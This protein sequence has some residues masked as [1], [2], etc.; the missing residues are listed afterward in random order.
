[1]KKMYMKP[2]VKISMNASLEGVFACRGDYGCG[3]R[4]SGGYKTSTCRRRDNSCNNPW[5]H[6]GSHDN[7]RGGCH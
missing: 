3:D 6:C 4:Q 7:H 1:M 5:D 2:E